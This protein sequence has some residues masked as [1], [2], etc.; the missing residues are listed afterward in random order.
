METGKIDNMCEALRDLKMCEF[1]MA[2]LECLYSHNQICVL[3]LFFLVNSF[4]HAH[5]LPVKIISI[6]IQKIVYTPFSC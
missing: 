5:E 6:Y 1:Q 3:F 4:S 2:F